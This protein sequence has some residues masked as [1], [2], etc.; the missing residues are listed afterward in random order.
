[1]I[2]RIFGLLLFIWMACAIVSSAP[3][4]F[5]HHGTRFQTEMAVLVFCS[6]LAA[7]GLVL[8]FRKQPPA[9]EPDSSGETSDAEH[10]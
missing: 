7:L 4:T 2:K 6:A 5:R 8:V 10:K 1:M 9:E 3:E